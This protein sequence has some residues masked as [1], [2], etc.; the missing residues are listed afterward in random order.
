M[1][2]V[3]LLLT[4]PDPK[5]RIART[6]LPPAGFPDAVQQEELDY[7]TDDFLQSLDDRVEDG[8]DWF[9]GYDEDLQHAL[10][11]HKNSFYCVISIS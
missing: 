5:P 11:S 9:K 8:Y 1:R 6:P 10:E 4:S 3:P 2:P 7:M